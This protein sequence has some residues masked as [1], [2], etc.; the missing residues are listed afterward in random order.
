MIEW[1]Q[2]L[3]KDL[4]RRRAVIVIGAGVSKHSTS[5]S[6]ARPPLWKK[7]LEDALVNCPNRTDLLPIE[8]ALREHDLLH[9]CEWLKKRFDEQ[10]PDYLRA[11]FSQPAF[12]SAPIHDAIL[13][14]DSRIVFSLNFDDIYERH[15]NGIHLG[16]HVVKNY[17]DPDVSEF[18]RG[19]RRYIIKVHG[20]LN[21]PDKLIFTQK[22]Y[23]NARVKHS[24]FYQAFDATLL[25][26]TFLFIGCGLS[27]PDI[28]LLLENQNFG[29]PTNSP[30]YFLTGSELSEDLVQSI[31]ANR[32]L[33]VLQYDKI[34]DA[35]AGLVDEL[36]GLSTL[37][38]AE[39]FELSQ[40]T[41][42]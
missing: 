16:S 5:A 12:P 13:D 7:F 31:R 28:N 2:P 39:R 11:T 27:D 32:N 15:A 42:W 8:A 10:W 35:H 33:K 26:H 3:I 34:D 37:V 9:A 30:H 24:A 17:H 29:F 22:D 41:F 38:E 14:L 40:T 36:N 21:V 1:P 19:A 23:S 4:A 6:G 20:T 25:T 18:L